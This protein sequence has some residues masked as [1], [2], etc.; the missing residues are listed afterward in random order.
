MSALKDKSMDTLDSEIGLVDV[1]VDYS[2]LT[3]GVAVGVSLLIGLLVF[4]QKNGLL[5]LQLL[6]ISFFGCGLLLCIKLYL[7]NKT[8]EKIELPNKKVWIEQ[9][10]KPGPAGVIP[11]YRVQV[12]HID[13]PYG[14]PKRIQ[15]FPFQQD[16][17]F[18]SLTE[19]RK[20][21]LDLLELD[22]AFLDKSHVA[23]FFMHIRQERYV[24]A[25]AF[26]LVGIVLFCVG[27]GLSS[28]A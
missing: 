12:S 28:V 5:F 8:V 3:R 17:Y 15:A 11:R 27:Y 9:F 19:A 20:L 24:A 23:F 7:C 14:A 1:G 21:A 16:N 22:Q 25:F 13:S 26:F 18:E 2:E 6:G 10:R 4:G